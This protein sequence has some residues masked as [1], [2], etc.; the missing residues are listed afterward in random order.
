MELGEEGFG[1]ADIVGGLPGQGWGWRR[2]GW[3]AGYG[4][5]GLLEVVQ[6]GGEEVPEMGEGGGVRG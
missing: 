3:E 1:L 5:Q 2:E 4:A 6:V